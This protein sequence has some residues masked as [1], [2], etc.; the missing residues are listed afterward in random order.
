MSSRDKLLYTVLFGFIAGIFIE[1]TFLKITAPLL[2]FVS[3]A[4][5]FFFLV[6]KTKIQISILTGLIAVSCFLGVL[7][8]T[9][10]TETFSFLSEKV[11]EV[12][13]LNG[14]VAADPDVREFNTKLTVKTETDTVLV[15]VPNGDYV[16]GDEVTVEGKLER[17]ENF[18]TDTG[19]TFDYISYLG[20]DDIYLVIPKAAVSIESHGRGNIVLRILYKIK[21]RILAVFEHVLPEKERALLGGILL[22]TKE[23]LPKETRDALVVTGTIHIV[24]LS[25]YNV[26]VVAGFFMYLLRG[27]SRVFSVSGGVLGILL[28]V[29]MTGASSTAVRAGV[30]AGLVLVA[31][32]IGRP[33]DA[34]RILLITGVAMLIVNS[35]LLTDDISFQL[36]FLATA[37]IIFLE[38]IIREYLQFLRWNWLMSLVS[39]TLAA[40]IA[41]LPFLLFTMGT[42]SLVALPINI[43]ILP[44][45]ELVML[46]GAATALLGIIVVHFAVPL[47]YITYLFLHFLIFIITTG[48]K[49]PFAAVTVPQFPWWIV[50]LLYGLMILGVYAESQNRVIKK[51]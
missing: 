4:A 22:G 32:F 43:L 44:F 39:V 24:A 38:P 23:S 30:M 51:V 15:T 3:V 18:E 27:A 33:H 5:A 10:G 31:R 1:A 37:G 41:V 9:I 45:V 14:I 7:R 8:H 47:G 28:F 2:I 42:L 50:T 26:S 48:A 34:A 12:V 49:I 40:Q 17:P 36:S 35:K 19:R 29:L 20:K 21:H 46:L 11:G 6:E 13:T 25:G 16:Y